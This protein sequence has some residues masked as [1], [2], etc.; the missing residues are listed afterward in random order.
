MIFDLRSSAQSAQG[1]YCVAIVGAGA[2]GIVLA[3]ELAKRGRRVVL[4]ESGG[5]GHERSAFDLNRGEVVGLAYD[6]LH[7]GRFRRLGG[8]TTEWGGQILELDEIDFEHRPWVPGSG[9]PFGKSVLGPYYNR[10]IDFLGLGKAIPAD[11]AVWRALDKAEPQFGEDFASVFSRWCPERDFARLQAQALK[12]DPNLTVVL[13]ATACELLL[14][15]RPDRIRGIRCRSLNGHEAVVE[16]DR[17]VLCL[18]GVE[19]SRFLLQA[20]QDRPA[21]WNRHGLV[22]RH[23]TDHIACTG[24]TLT[25]CVLQPP[26]DYFGYLVTDGFTY[27]P[28]IKLAPQ[29]QARLKSLNVAAT[30]VV[31]SAASER[32]D[33]VSRAANLIRRHRPGELTLAQ[34][35]LLSGEI[36]RRGVGALGARRAK[37]KPWTEMAVRVHCEQAPLSDSRITL[38]DQRDPIGLYRAR[39]DWRTSAMEL[40]SIQAFVTALAKAFLDRGLGLITPEPDL[41]SRPDRF[42][43]TF[44]DSFHHMGGTRM[45]ETAAGGVVDVNLRLHGVENVFVCSSSVFPSSGFSNPTHTILAL[46]FRLADHLAASAKPLPVAQMGRP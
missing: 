3:T 45:A 6:G 21:P 4:L 44:Q 33:R 9:W 1:R 13:H 23:F 17:F 14:G 32:A 35:R 30:M 22:G 27:H 5:I 42:I 20:V 15:E 24:G 28:K 18:G 19:T 34:W 29:A 41:I 26:P 7:N 37:S 43:E 31:R 11:C 38:S 12:T 16:A 36:F 39:L 46:A 8:S 40:E 2:A 25:Q 10:V